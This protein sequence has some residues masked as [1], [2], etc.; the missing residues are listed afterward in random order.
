MIDDDRSICELIADY[1]QKYTRYEIDCAVNS[2]M[3]LEKIKVYNYDLILLDIELKNE[4]GLDIITSIK[5]RFLGPILYVSCHG[6]RNTVISGLKLGA[7]DY[8]V[9]PFDFEE[10]FLRIDRSLERSG[11]LKLVEIENYT[12]NTV[13]NE[14]TKDGKKLDLGDVAAE[15]L[16]LI[17]RNK[18]QVVSREMISN[19]VWGVAYEYNTRVIDTHLSVIRKETMDGRIR[20]KRGVGYI[21][22][23]K[24]D[25]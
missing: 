17:L 20:T 16:I 21:F 22:E 4:S 7:D 15:I 2:Q 3:A 5:E 8:I 23:V 18:N 13:N 12:I 10:L 6:D 14:V 25:K 11:V 19:S 1:G 9:K 24:D